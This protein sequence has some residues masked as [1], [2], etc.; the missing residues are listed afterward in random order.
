MLSM[1]LFITF[2]TIAAAIQRVDLC[3]PLAGFQYQKFVFMDRSTPIKDSASTILPIQSLT[4]E[5]DCPLDNPLTSASAKMLSLSIGRLKPPR[6]SD[7][8]AFGVVLSLS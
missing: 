8:D 3:G 5:A 1:I 2:F 7:N 4:S 6:L